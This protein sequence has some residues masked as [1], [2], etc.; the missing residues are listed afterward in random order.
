MM[1][2]RAHPGDFREEKGGGGRRG[3]GNTSRYVRRC[4]HLSCFTRPSRCMYKYLHDNNVS[5][6]NP[7]SVC[8]YLHVHMYDIHINQKSCVL[9]SVDVCQK[10]KKLWY[11]CA[12]STTYV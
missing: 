4:K 6:I 3:G 7:D 2:K 8:I 1:R 5:C 11:V 9:C 10:K 12:R